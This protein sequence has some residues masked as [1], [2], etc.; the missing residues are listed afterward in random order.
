MSSLA[1]H[2]RI[3][4]ASASSDAV[5]L[6][7]DGF[8][9]TDVVP[10]TSAQTTSLLQLAEH[11]TWTLRAFGGAW[12]DTDEQTSKTWCDEC[13]NM[14]KTSGN[15][16]LQRSGATL[17]AAVMTQLSASPYGYMEKVYARCAE[18]VVWLLKHC[19]AT[20]LKGSVGLGALEV[21]H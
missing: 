9:N 3:T 1:S 19:R 10:T 17:L 20:S 18:G 14:I 21:A 4:L 8:L 16:A 11:A 2:I 6:A 7:S 15:V 12:D 13:L 5:S